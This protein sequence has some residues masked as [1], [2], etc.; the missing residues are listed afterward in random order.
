MLLDPTVRK[1]LTEEGMEE[2]C[3]GLVLAVSGGAD[4]MAM[5][6]WYASRTP[7]YPLTVAHVHHGLRPESDGEE[8]LVRRQCELFGI[9]CRVLHTDVR[10]EMLHGETVESAARR[11]R[12]AFLRQVALDVGASH[13]AT[14][15]TM[16]DQAETVLLHLI[17]GAGL[18]GLCG[19]LPKR[20]EEGITL[21]RPLIRCSR[22]STEAF[23]EEQGISYAL[24]SSNEDLSYTRN[25]IRH[26]VLPTL[27]KINPNISAALG[28][29]ATSLQ[30][31]QRAAQ[32]RA[33]TFLSTQSEALSADRLKTLPE[34]DRAEVLRLMF[35][36]KGKTLS[37]EQTA[38]ALGLL[39]K[40]EGTVEFDRR[41]RLHLGQN[42][43]TLTENAPARFVEPMIV[44]EETLLPDG[45][46]LGLIPTVATEENRG[47]LFIA[48]LP[49]TLRTRRAG[50][51][52]ST[53]GGTKSLAKR[54]M[55][56]KIPA[57]KRDDLLLLADGRTVI[58]CEGVGISETHKPTL[59]K[60]GYFP[61]LSEK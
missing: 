14:A 45:R 20:T 56:L 22:S 5:L 48:P 28:R 58:W 19:I 46:I 31:Y 30:G 61:L 34:S 8:E 50:D 2:A 26:E 49:L 35:E 51:K 38:Q 60:Q 54:M 40:A 16:D 9:P 6:G 3:R 33:E 42:C 10:R 43:L 37:A 59:G 39:E 53:A 12:Y 57:H 29:T 23:C 27:R 24:D 44:T 32:F 4:S 36:R 55:E 17:H 47:A 25:R 11:L 7:S 13:L 41:W 15:H 18:R 21:I 1:T 52:I